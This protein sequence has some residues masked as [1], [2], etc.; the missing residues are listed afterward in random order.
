MRVLALVLAVAWL[1]AFPAPLDSQ[2]VLERYGIALAGLLAPKAVVFVYSVSQ[3]GPENIEQRH[4][5]YR[6]GIDVRDETLAVNGLALKRKRVRIGHRPDPY[7]VLALAPRPDAYEML[8]VK[9]IADGSHLDYVYQTQPLVH[10]GGF[11][12]DRVTIDGESFLPRVVEFHTSGALASGSGSVKF[13][14]AG[15]YWVPLVASASAAIGGSVAR[16]RIVFSD[17]E[18]PSSLPRSTF[19]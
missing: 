9:S 1:G 17:Y 5:I 8:F 13:G 14:S 7:G 18:F 15:G 19:L 4:R 2:V 10:G 11:V 3:A 12:V 16:E 6:S